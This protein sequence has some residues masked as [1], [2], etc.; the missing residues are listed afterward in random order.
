ALLL[1]LLLA[2][3][4]P[5]APAIDV[6]V[7]TG[8]QFTGLHSDFA[9]QYYVLYTELDDTAQLTDVS[10]DALPS[11]LRT[12]LSAN[13]LTWSDMPGLL[14][15]AFLWDA[16][17]VL[18]PTHSLAKV[19]T[20][21][22]RT[23][24]EVVVPPKAFERAGCQ[25]RE[26]VLPD[27]TRFHRSLNC[28]ASQLSRAVQCA[29]DAADDNS[30]PAYAAVWGDGGEDDTL[31]E[32]TVQRHAYLSDAD[33]AP[34]LMFA[35]HTTAY[36]VGYTQCPLTPSMVIPCAPYNL[37]NQSRFCTPEPG[38]VASAWLTK[39]A[40]DHKQD[41]TWLLVPLCIVVFVTFGT[42]AVY[43][44]KS[45]LRDEARREI[46]LFMRENRHLFDNGAVEAF[47]VPKRKGK[48][49][50]STRTS[51]Q[52]RSSS[53][54]SSSSIDSD[55]SAYSSHSSADLDGSQVS[56]SYDE[57]NQ[58]AAAFEHFDATIGLSASAF[59]PL[60][61]NARMNPL[62]NGAE[63]GLENGDTTPDEATARRNEM[64][65]QSFR[66]FESHRKIRRLRIPI[67]E[68]QLLRPLSRGATGEVWLALHN[69]SQVAI[70]Q[71]V[72]EKRRLLPEMEMFLAEIYL[73]AQ[74]KHPHIVTLIGIA[75]NTLEHVIMVQE[76]MEGGD[77]QHFLA[78]QC[79]N[80]NTSAAPISSGNTI[81]R[82]SSSMSGG[83]PQVDEA[84]AIAA[85]SSGS[86]AGGLGAAANGL[87]HSTHSLHSSHFTWSKQKLAIAQ[88]VTSALAYLHALTPKVLHR[89]VKSRNV[90][91][92]SSLDAKLCD[93]G[94]SRRKCSGNDD[95]TN[96][97]ATAAAGTLSWTAP[98]LLLGEEYTEKVDIYSLGVLLS[99]LDTCTLPYHDPASLSERLVQHPLRLMRRILD[100]GLRPQL[101]PDCPL[102]IT[103]LIAACVSRNPK[104]RPSAADV[105][106]WLAS[107]RGERLLRK[108]SSV[109]IS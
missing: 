36:E 6:P 17:Y 30:A 85:T 35:L 71:L 31:P 45:A 94:V 95:E 107:A 56:L 34:N 80:N 4:P 55:D 33:N 92:S 83:L 41:K 63:Q 10:A 46:D 61:S 60:A 43:R 39:Y 86:F 87:I 49:A 5:R 73:M 22:G 32:V 28:K 58:N 25:V 65:I 54:S 21:C 57:G 104:L 18:T 99:E 3:T 66:L 105:G 15:R 52:H 70:K 96:L 91:L 109:L 89:D 1:L 90:L 62:Q 68:L 79:S 53:Y 8:F 72:S 13:S 97:T 101:S 67:G 11:E 19:Y 47:L 2:S 40:A 103:H 50:R 16:G 42:V 106:A 82:R 37:V 88:A 20:R 27:G 75:W 29:V 44:Y 102:P 76:Y 81:G 23:M 93:F 77:L 7:E 14:Q 69:N 108:S 84:A 12:E 26:C 24:A 59:D 9:Q 98:E 38:D 100:D 74:L 48:C 78:Q 64:A 51:R